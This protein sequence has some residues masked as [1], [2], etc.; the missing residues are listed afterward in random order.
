[1]SIFKN[2]Q[3]FKDNINSF[4]SSLITAGFYPN[5]PLQRPYEPLKTK[6]W[7][8]QS[9]GRLVHVRVKVIL[10][11]NQPMYSTFQRDNHDFCPSYPLSK[12][13]LRKPEVRN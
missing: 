3:K 6:P 12:G 7:G 1:M 13:D 2:F 8:I 5:N 11:I 9:A 10:T 4:G